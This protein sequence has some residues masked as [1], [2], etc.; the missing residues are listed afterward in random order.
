MKLMCPAKRLAKLAFPF[1]LIA[2]LFSISVSAQRSKKAT[3]VKKSGREAKDARKD[4]RKG[5]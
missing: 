4:S 2:L 3:P 1:F 5:Q